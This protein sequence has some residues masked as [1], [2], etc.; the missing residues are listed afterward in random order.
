MIARI[1]RTKIDPHRADEYRKFAQSRSLPMFRKQR[2]FA[3]VVFAAREDERAVISFW[4]ESRDADALGFSPTY[5]ATVDEIDATGFLRGEM[6]VE[7]FRVDG[8]FL[9]GLT[10]DWEVE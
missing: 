4:R 10:G 8:A 9:E 2:G 1:W 6:T 3:G 5:K 7:I